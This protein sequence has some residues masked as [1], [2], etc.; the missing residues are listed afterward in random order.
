MGWVSGRQD[1]GGLA[2]NQRHILKRLTLHLETR[3]SGVGGGAGWGRRW[4][5][6]AQE[7][8]VCELLAQRSRG[9]FHF[10]GYGSRP[11]V[12]TGEAETVEAVKGV[13]RPFLFQ[14]FQ[15]ALE[16]SNHP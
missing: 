11:M 15:R 9:H 4:H 3:T 13:N 1:G 10:L 7:T 8:M 16:G 6:G 14:I 2:T 5:R 12:G